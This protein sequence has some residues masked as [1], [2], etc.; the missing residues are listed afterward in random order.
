MASAKDYRYL[1]ILRPG[2]DDAIIQYLDSL[3]F[4]A[5][6]QVLIEALQ[7][8]MLNRYTLADVMEE[9]SFIET[10]LRDLKKTRPISIQS[11][12]VHEDVIEEQVT[13]DL[14]QKL[15]DFGL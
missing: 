10:I 8:H 3:P 11:D 15:V 14:K 9:L 13:P 1:F 12:T 7:M 5:K 6:R 2:V 4:G